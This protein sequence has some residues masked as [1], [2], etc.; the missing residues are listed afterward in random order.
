VHR[1][2]AGGGALRGE[3]LTSPGVGLL[4]RE[5]P[6]RGAVA[7][8]LGSRTDAEAVVTLLE[9][10]RVARDAYGAMQS[11]LGRHGLT[12][13]KWALLMQ[14]HTAP[15]GKL[16]PS[17]LASRLLVTKGAVSAL[18]R[19]AERARLIRR[20]THPTDRRKYYVALAPRGRRVVARV[21]PLHTRRIAAYMSVLSEAERR[22]LGEALGKLHAALPALC[23]RSPGD[24][25]RVHKTSRRIG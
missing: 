14:L 4:L 6:D 17:A 12:D 1:P 11:S 7:Q 19:G 20:L 10:L 3:P 9:L 5:L 2:V 13:A 8:V 22:S 16:L 25:G 21:L 24:S 18:L 15:S 23:P